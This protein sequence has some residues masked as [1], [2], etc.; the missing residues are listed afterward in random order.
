MSLSRKQLGSS[1]LLVTE[2][3]LGTMTFGVQN[4]EEEGHAQLD[5]AVK[6]RGVNFIDT[7]EMYPVP[8]SDSRWKP[9]RTEEIVGTWLA[10]NPEW[11]EK[12]VVATKVS[13]FNPVSDTAANRTVPPSEPIPARLDAESVLAAC[14][15]SLRRLQT[16]YIDLY[17]LHWPDRYVPLWGSQSYDPAQERAD[18]VSIAETARALKQLLDAGKIKAYGLSNETTFGV[19]EWARVA[20]ELDMPPPASIQNAFSLLNR[21]FEQSLAEAC[22]PSNHNVGLLPWSALCGGLLTGKYTAGWA[23]GEA[24]SAGPKDGRLTIFGPKFM[25]RWADPNDNTKSAVRAYQ[26]VA[27]RYG[28]SLTTLSLAWCR[29]RWYHSSCIIGAT[30]LAQLKEDIDAFDPEVVPLLSQE[31]LKEVDAI[32][33]SCPNPCLS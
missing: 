17:Q 21:D 11:R 30:T 32:H 29:S 4:S 24:C 13:G 28:V 12:V 26:A 31:V 9:G 27:D 23:E 33:N 2:V 15:A 5:Y 3:C 19:C 16:T 10:K 14:A 7:A 22:A 1:A 25:T 18:S 8:S 6:D 20:K